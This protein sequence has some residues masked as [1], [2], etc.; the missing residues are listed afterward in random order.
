MFLATIRARLRLAAA[1]IALILLGAATLGWWTVRHLANDVERRVQDAARVQSLTNRFAFDVADELRAGEAYI[2]EPSARLEGEFN[3]RGRDAHRVQAILVRSQLAAAARDS[4]SDA[5]LVARI[6]GEL[7]TLENT[8]ARAHRLTDLGDVAGARAVLAVPGDAEAKLRDDVAALGANQANRVLEFGAL[9]MRVATNRA[10]LLAA[11][12]AAVIGLLALLAWALGQSIA[13]PLQQLVSHAEALHRGDR[14]RRTDE[15][16]MPGEFRVLATAMND[17]SASLASLAETQAALHHAEKLAA[18]GTLISGVAHELNNPLQTILLQTEILKAG[19]RDP[20]TIAELETIATQV[21][22]SRTIITD[23]LTSV[24]R[25][26]AHRDTAPLESA[27]HALEPE[28][29]QLATREGASL[30]FFVVKPLPPLIVDRVGMAQVL[31]N[32]VSNGAAAAGGGGT[33]YVRASRCVGGCEITVD[34]TGPGI[35]AEHLARIFEPFFSTK[36][37]G[38]GTGLGLPVSRGIVESMGGTLTVESH[39]A[40]PRT[41]A[42]FRVFLPIGQP[43]VA[44]AGPAPRSVTPVA[45][46]P[47]VAPDGAVPPRPLMLVV[48]DEI[49]IQN[50]V[51]QIFVRRDWAVDRASDGLQALA[52]IEARRLA[53]ARYDVVFCDL[54]MPAMSGMQLHDA[55]ARQAPELLQRLVFLSGDLVSDDVRDFVARSSCRVLSKPLTTDT[56]VGVA[57]EMARATV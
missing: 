26:N 31:T 53:G 35:R 20:R 2:V 24:R 11:V 14:E 49:V 42:R 28:L 57:E 22:R 21:A 7:S 33:V 15:R 9:T 39:W 38:K 40:G 47:V 54:R 12:L 48:D 43:A 17:A 3:E 8:Y 56:L 52:R 29:A 4:A 27:L 5:E 16:G 30:N 6:D 18:I 51:Y 1:A 13:Q 19:A 55:I 41:G 32:L 37:V 23:L 44:A 36:D 45:G 50:L 10:I 34:D 46:A 25:E